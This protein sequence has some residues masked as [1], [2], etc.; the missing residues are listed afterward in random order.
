MNEFFATLSDRKGQL[1]STII[2]HIQLS[3]IALSL[4]LL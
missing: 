3:F 1:F 4:Q 2:E